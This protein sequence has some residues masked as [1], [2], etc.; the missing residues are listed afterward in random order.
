M[1]H[2]SWP[3]MLLPPCPAAPHPMQSDRVT[4]S[5]VEVTVTQP[6]LGPPEGPIKANY[7]GHW[8]VRVGA[9]HCLGS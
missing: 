4:I 1:L 7:D 2:P 6:R 5:G 8:G 3:D 9:W